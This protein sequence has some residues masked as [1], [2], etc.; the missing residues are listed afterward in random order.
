MNTLTLN[1]NTKKVLLVMQQNEVTEHLIYERLAKRVKDPEDSACSSA[2]PTK[3]CAMRRS[4]K[5]DGCRG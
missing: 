5:I 4:G 1:D 3:R 2:L